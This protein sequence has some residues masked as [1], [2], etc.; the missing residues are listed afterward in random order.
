M[1]KLLI[2]LFCLCLVGCGKVTKE[3]EKINKEDKIQKY[4][5][6]SSVDRLV[7]K[8]ENNYE[9]VYYENDKIVK[10]ESAIKFDTKEEA[11]RHYKEESYGSSETLKCIYDVF[12]VEELEDYWEDYKDLNKDELIDYMGNANY[13]LVATAS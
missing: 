7:F 4:S 6:V 2:L 1:K 11:Q 10:V 9:V 12:I 3:K 5:L 8:N 13:I